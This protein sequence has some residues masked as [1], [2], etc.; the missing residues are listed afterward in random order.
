M[1]HFIDKPKYIYIF[2]YIEIFKSNRRNRVIIRQ[3]FSSMSNIYSWAI[4]ERYK[5][6]L[7]KMKK[8]KEADDN[9]KTRRS[10]IT[11][12]SMYVCMYV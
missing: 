7:K 12:R 11:H 1:R 6:T 5:V 10:N 9:K 4:N 2:V 8:K 3:L